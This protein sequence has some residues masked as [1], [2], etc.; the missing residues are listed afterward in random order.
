M[1]DPDGRDEHVPHGVVR[2][3]VVLPGLHGQVQPGLHVDQS[4]PKALLEELPHLVH[5]DWSL[6]R[7]RFTHTLL[8]RFGWW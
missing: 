1:L 6:P 2:A 3:V 8:Y 5:G 7:V 4:W